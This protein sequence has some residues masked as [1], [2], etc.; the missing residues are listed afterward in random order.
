VSVHD[1]PGLRELARR[2]EQAVGLDL[3]AYKAK[4]LRRRIAVRMRAHGVHTYE[5]YVTLLDADPGELERLIDALTIN[6]TKFFRNGEAWSWLGRQ[7]LPGLLRERDGALRAWSAGCASGE[8]AYTVAMLLART[9]AD[10]GHPDWFARCR[11]DASDIDRV[12]LDRARAGRY[13]AAAFSE[14]QAAWVDPWRRALGADEY[15]VAPEVRERVRV[16]RCDMLAEPAPEPPYDLVVCRNVIIYFDRPSQERLMM[17]FHDAL[18]PGGCLMLGKVE[19]LFG[20]ARTRF[21]LLEPRERIYR[22]AA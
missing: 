4:C 5:E 14:C 10:L 20:P 19:T 22:K 18:A 3:E 15:Q 17:V 11:V 9:A 16:V 7:V 21:E 2:I 12:S 8:E 13:P 6:V 1:E